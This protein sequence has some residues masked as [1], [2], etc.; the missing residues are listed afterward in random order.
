ML[1]LL[2]GS[3]DAVVEDHFVGLE[4][5][6]AVHLEGQHLTQVFARGRGQHD[7][8]AQGL[9]PGKLEFEVPQANPPLPYMPP[10]FAILGRRITW[11]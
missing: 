11:L 8:L 3:Q 9:V 2:V 10:D 4:R 7:D 6:V 5:R 1:A